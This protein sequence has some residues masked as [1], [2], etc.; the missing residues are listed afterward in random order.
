MTIAYLN[1]KFTPLEKARVS[2]MDRGF[3]FGDG[4]YE[5]FLAYEEKLFA[6]EKHLNRLRKS[7]A[8]IKINL[9]LSNEELINL[10]QQLIKK[11]GGGSQK[12]YLQITRGTATTRNLAFDDKL[13][14]T[15]FAF[16][17]PLITYDIE[18]LSPGIS[19]IT[20]SDIRWKQCNTKT[21]TLLA[22]V[23]LRQQAEEN[24]YDEAILIE[25]GFALEGTASNLFVVKKD[26]I[27]TP[28]LENNLLGGITRETI[29]RLAEEYQLPIR[30]EPVSLELL[31]AADEIWLTGS[32]REISPVVKLNNSSVGTGQA[33]PWWYKMITLLKEYKQ[34]WI[35]EHE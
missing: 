14:P 32:S 16:S 27:T 29:I 3:L 6:I 12:L 18:A 34:Q 11:N 20:L 4:A 10:F 8:T 25:N 22:N 17:Q 31:R 1:G 30:V 2:P 13:T 19:A 33:G 5:V 35:A 9:A 26:Q 21:T 24:G 23:L 15:I 28:P 7:L